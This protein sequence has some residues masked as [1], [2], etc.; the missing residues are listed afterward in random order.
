MRVILKSR[1][2]SY[3]ANGEYNEKTGEITV[4]KGS[5]I[6]SHRDVS[7]KFHGG[8]KTQRYRISYVDDEGILVENIRFKSPSTAANFVTGN[9]TNGMIAWKDE[10]KT[11]LKDLI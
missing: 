8:S 3:E 4:L 7:E 9:S 1:N 11:K 6:S 10:N 2:G 5:K